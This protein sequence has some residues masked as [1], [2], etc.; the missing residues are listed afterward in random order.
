MLGIISW[1]SRLLKRRF[2]KTTNLVKNLLPSHGC[3]STILSVM[4]P[5]CL[6]YLSQPHSAA[7]HSCVPSTVT[8]SGQSP[9][10]I[11]VYRA[12]DA[13]VHTWSQAE[14]TKGKH[15]TSKRTVN[16]EEPTVGG[17]LTIR[18]KSQLPPIIAAWCGPPVEYS[19]SSFVFSKGRLRRL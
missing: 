7:A 14:G 17:G 10:A 6:L 9:L 4:L 15:L 2:Y 16:F 19:W 1:K 5:R 18:E 12:Q 3:I 13:L 11:S 8:G